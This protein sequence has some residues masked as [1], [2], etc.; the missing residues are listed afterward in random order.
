MR[1]TIL[2]KLLNPGGVPFVRERVSD[3]DAALRSSSNRYGIVTQPTQIA[4]VIYDE[5]DAEFV[6]PFTKTTMMREAYDW[7]CSVKPS[8]RGFSWHADCECSGLVMVRRV[9]FI[10][11]PHEIVP[12]NDL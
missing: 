7:N 4:P 1:K 11:Y 12:R 8:R 3:S 6:D 2:H 5:A 9:K 10:K